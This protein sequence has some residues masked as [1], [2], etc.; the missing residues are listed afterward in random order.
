MNSDSEHALT[1]RGTRL[2]PYVVTISCGVLLVYCAVRGEP[3]N[4]SNEDGLLEWG[5]VY[6]LGVAALLAGAALAFDRH[7]V[8]AQKGFLIALIVLLALAVGEELSWGQRIFE[9]E[10]PEALTKESGGLIQAG[11]KDTTLHNLSFRSKYLK[12]S[13]GGLIFGVVLLTGL[14]VHGIWL[15]RAIRRGDERARRLVARFGVFVPPLE[16]GVLVFS[17]A[18]VLHFL[19]PLQLTESREY[20]EFVIAFVFAFMLVRSYF[21]QQPRVRARVSGA[22]LLAVGVWAIGSFAVL[23]ASS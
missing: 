15:P 22:L 5:T 4:V 18:L 1:S 23:M 3:F 13:I 20:K 16:L 11:H 6:F 9:W 17:A 21:A 2:L 19:K 10:V 14:F 8:R 7:L 12:F